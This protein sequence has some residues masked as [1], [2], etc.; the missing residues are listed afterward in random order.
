MR[1]S[2]RFLGMASAASLAGTALAGCSNQV[3]NGSVCFIGGDNAITLAAPTGEITEGGSV[4]Y[5]A[6]INAGREFGENDFQAMRIDQDRVVGRETNLSVSS[7][8][9]SCVMF[10]GISGDS[11]SYPVESW[12]GV[13]LRYPELQSNLD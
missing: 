5:E 1:I 7:D 12:D 13:V 4:V 6:F 2:G 10:D 9:K 3:D 8:G 11:F